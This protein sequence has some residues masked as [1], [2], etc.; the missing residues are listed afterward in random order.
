MGETASPRFPLLGRNA[1]TRNRRMEAGG[2]GEKKRSSVAIIIPSLRTR[3]YTCVCIS[4]SLSGPIGVNTLAQ[5]ERVRAIR[6]DLI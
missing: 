6:R 2:R 5:S 4:V 1:R 3:V